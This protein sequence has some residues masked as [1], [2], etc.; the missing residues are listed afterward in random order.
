[1][2]GRA[3]PLDGLAEQTLAAFDLGR[4]QALEDWLDRSPPGVSAVYPNF[5]YVRAEMTAQAQVRSTV[6]SM[7]R[8]DHHH[9]ALSAEFGHESPWRLPSR[10][11][12][13]DFDGALGPGCPCEF[14]VTGEQ[15]CAH[16]FGECYVGS[17]VDGEV[18]PQ[19]PAAGEQG[20]VRCPLRGQRSQ[21]IEGEAGAPRVESACLE[22]SAQH[23]CNLQVG[24]FGDGQPLATQPG[25][26]LVAVGAVIG[27]GDDQDTGVSDDHGR[28][29]WRPQRPS[30]GP[31]HQIARQR[32]QGSPPA[33]AGLLLQSAAPAGTPGETGEQLP[34]AD[35]GSHECARAHP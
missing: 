30:A 13:E 23:R 25:P 18:V 6:A 27:Q 19:L 35:G 12:W 10:C 29:G 14:L 3:G 21:V 17:V 34:R 8:P 5:D 16:G 28:R 7:G 11:R 22:L 9:P 2:D 26:G 15:G 1:V 31:I 32:G 4:W 20:T 24:E 33:S